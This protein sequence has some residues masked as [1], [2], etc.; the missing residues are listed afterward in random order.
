VIDFDRLMIVGPLYDGIP[1]L[2]PEFACGDD[3]H[4]NPAAY[5]AMGEFVDLTLFSTGRLQQ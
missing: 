5:R 3:V 2:K 4:P 1:G